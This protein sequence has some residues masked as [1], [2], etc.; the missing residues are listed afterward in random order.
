MPMSARPWADVGIALLGH[1][2]IYIY[3]RALTGRQKQMAVIAQ[4]AWQQVTEVP[5]SLHGALANNRAQ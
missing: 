3:T 4:Q 5:S 2:I 1:H